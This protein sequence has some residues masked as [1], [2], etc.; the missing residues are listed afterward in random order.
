MTDEASARRRVVIV[1]DLADIR[2]IL[3]L[4]PEHGDPSGW[5][6][7][8]RI[9][10]VAPDVV[11]VILSGN[12]VQDAAPEEAGLAATVLEKGMPPDELNAALVQLLGL[13]PAARRAATTDARSS[14][15]ARLDR[16]QRDLARTTAELAAFASLA[17]HDLA[18]PLQVAYGYLEM[19]RSDLG[20]TLDSTPAEWLDA[21]LSAMERMRLLVQDILA[22]GRA[23]TRE[24]DP[25]PVDLELV[26]DQALARLAPSSMDVRRVGLPTVMGD[27]GQLVDVVHRLLEN[28]LRFGGG[29]GVA[30]T[31]DL[32]ADGWIVTVADDGPGVPA[33]LRD[34]VFEVFQRTSSPVG[35]GAGLG[36]AVCRKLVERH[37]GEIWLEFPTTRASGAVFR[38]RLPHQ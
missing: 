11:V 32:A 33:E 30:V 20:D 15:A 9:K 22:F 2:Q 4:L 36:L 25:V 35:K 1:D 17:G 29:L 28:A 18:Q 3:E 5:Q 27:E 13:E 38:F 16:Q 26:V 10:A 31:A 6:A 14:A 37:R 12:H 23:G 21:A 7:L 24:V 19:L 34:R 8:P